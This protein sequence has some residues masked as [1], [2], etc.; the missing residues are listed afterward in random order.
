MQ[1]QKPG[2]DDADPN[3]V[4]AGGRAI[5]EVGKPSRG[6][7]IENKSQNNNKKKEK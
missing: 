3:A 1:N 6:L 4:G 5:E 2:D 7:K